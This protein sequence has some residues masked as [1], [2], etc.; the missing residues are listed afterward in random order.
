MKESWHKRPA[1][2]ACVCVCVCVCVGKA[3]NV[4][5]VRMRIR[6]RVAALPLPLLPLTGREL[7]RPPVNDVC[8]DFLPMTFVAFAFCCCYWCCAV[9]SRYHFLFG[10]CRPAHNMMRNKKKK[11]QQKKTK[12][13]RNE[14]AS[15]LVRRAWETAP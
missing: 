7:R 13:E 10:Q 1:R 9:G 15:D 3:T 6:M 5:A 8:F 11:K 12:K 4:T 2:G 14:T